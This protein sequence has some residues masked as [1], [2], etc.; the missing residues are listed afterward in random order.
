MKKVVMV[1]LV[2]ILAG[3]IA[4]AAP[5]KEGGAGDG[6]GDYPNKPIKCILPF[7]PGGGTDTFARTLLKYVNPTL[8]HPIAIVNIEGASGLVGAMEFYNGPNDGYTIM[9]HAVDLV[10]GYTL[11]KQ[12]PIP[13]WKELPT[14]C[15]A[16]IDYQGAFA[17]KQSGFKTVEDFV[18]YA[19][20]NPGKITYGTVGARN[21]NNRN[22][23]MIID[24]L[25]LTGL[26]TMVPYDN[27]G[28]IRTA[29]L[30]NHIQ[31]SQASVGDFNTLISSG[32]AVPLVLVSDRRT[33]LAPNVPTSV[34]KGLKDLTA[35]IPRGFYA[36][37]GTNPA[38]IKFLEEKFKAGV[39]NPEFVAEITRL[40]TDPVFIP[41]AEALKLCEEMYNQFK[42]Y[43]DNL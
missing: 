33:K 16:G 21:I 37:K 40:Y 28:Q 42:P 6:L 38:I 10:V 23:A 2:L 34:E 24:G 22:A 30:G 12:T 5:G 39:E 20:A 35:L 4:F 31:V 43:F 26:V 3:G 8:K 32:D 11:S 9:A 25:G 17:S 29:L 41:G 18:T 7:A 27:G 15:W 14:I 13:L 1:L 19:K 36:A